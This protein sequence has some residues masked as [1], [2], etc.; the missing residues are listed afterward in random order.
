MISSEGCF[1]FGDD[2]DVIDLNKCVSFHPVALGQVF[3]YIMPRKPTT[4]WISVFYVMVI[5]YTFVNCCLSLFP[6]SAQISPRIYQQWG[7]NCILDPKCW[8]QFENTWFLWIKG[9]SDGENCCDNAS[10]ISWILL[11][12]Y[13]VG[14]WLSLKFEG[15]LI[16][17][18][19]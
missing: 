9:K 7:C 1:M 5:T 11:L 13:F 14:P 6:S 4:V 17:Y 12:L 15:A 19:C 18:L 3:T 16:Y 2:S 10:L 8:F